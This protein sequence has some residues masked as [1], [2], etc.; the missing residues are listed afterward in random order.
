MSEKL[1]IL[2][3]KRLKEHGKR[4]EIRWE[5]ILAHDVT[6][7]LVNFRGYNK[8]VAMEAAIRKCGLTKRHRTEIYDF[9]ETGARWSRKTRRIND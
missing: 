9:M 8:T 2:S 5:D 4:T 6:G 7:K 3:L 1:I